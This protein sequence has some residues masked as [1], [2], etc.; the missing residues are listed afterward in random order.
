MAEEKLTFTAAIIE[1]QKTL[2]NISSIEQ[3]FL[4]LPDID[5]PVLD[6]L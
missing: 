3:L 4:Q 5:F 6:I 2:Y 1:S